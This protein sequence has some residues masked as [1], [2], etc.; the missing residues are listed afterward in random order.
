MQLRFFNALFQEDLKRENALV[1][2]A[3]PRVYGVDHRNLSFLQC[4]FRL[5]CH[6]TKHESENS[7]SVQGFKH[8][9]SDFITTRKL[10]S[11]YVDSQDDFIDSARA[12]FCRLQPQ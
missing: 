11:I 2:G 8:F 7:F 5:L 4:C 9:R 3:F 1:I 10:F 6:L 12:I